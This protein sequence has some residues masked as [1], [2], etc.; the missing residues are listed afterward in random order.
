MNPEQARDI[1][2]IRSLG[3]VHVT[4]FEQ[5][6]ENGKITLFGE[7]TNLRCPQCGSEHVTKRSRYVRK[8]ADCPIEGNPVTLEIHC[9]RVD[10][11][12]MMASHKEGLSNVVP[13]ID[14][15][16]P[17]AWITLRLKTQIANEDYVDNTFKSLSKR[18]G[19]AENTIIKIFDE[20][21]AALEPELKY[22]DC[23]MIGIDE[24]HLG[25]MGKSRRPRMC[26]TIVNLSNQDTK[27]IDILPKNNKDTVLEAFKSFPF[28]D[29]IKWVC[30]DMHKPYVSAVQTF[31]P[32][33]NIIIDRFHVEA[34]LGIAINA[35][36]RCAGEYYEYEYGSLSDPNERAQQLDRF[37]KKPY[38][39]FWFRKKA[40]TYKEALQ[41][42]KTGQKDG[43]DAT[44]KQLNE[45]KKE[46]GQ[47][48]NLMT[49][50]DA[51][52]EYKAVFSVRNAFAEMYDKST[53]EEAEAA[54]YHAVSLLPDPKLLKR[55]DLTESQ[56]NQIR[57]LL[58]F[59]EYVK[60]VENWKSM[61]L[62]YFEAIYE[63]HRS[64]GPV[65]QWNRNID[66]AFNAGNGY[67][68]EHLR[69]KMLFGPGKVKL[70]DDFKFVPM[71]SD[72]TRA[73]M[74]LYAGCDENFPE[75]TMNY[76]H[77][78]IRGIA[79]APETK[80][81]TFVAEVAQ[82][83]TTASF[84]LLHEVFLAYPYLA[85][86]IAEKLD[87]HVSTEGHCEILGVSLEEFNATYN[88]IRAQIDAHLE[89]ESVLVN[90]GK[91]ADEA[92]EEDEFFDFDVEIDL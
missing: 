59:W 31:F 54:F 67:S 92:P 21:V 70:S 35:S 77:S 2:K 6:E 29:N 46:A 1:S 55:K 86:D 76:F 42:L 36:L 38:S 47:Y 79:K 53:K 69:A 74:A 8:I 43:K 49:L 52:P 87:N 11:H 89:D 28:P 66:R 12:N 45:A 3:N 85:F 13:V 4:C 68:F 91:T 75:Q 57:I 64:N 9:S 63:P 71:S 39:A 51:Y 58:P 40:S 26:A 5:N 17:G 73:A 27:L 72:H 25:E 44:S 20:K 80:G 88:L 84:S 23:T 50:C 34:Q 41:V 22:P 83:V 60:T 56:K 81:N 48:R 33:A 65:E 14:G 10:C 30:M 19:V 61:I 37:K 7:L 18:Y 24:V 15:I 90:V 62:N 78:I 16:V 32:Q 82:N